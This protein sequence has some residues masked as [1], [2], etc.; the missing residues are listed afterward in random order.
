MTGLGPARSDIL[1]PL[2]R[3]NIMPK[4][5]QASKGGKCL[6]TSEN[7][8][9]HYARYGAE[10]GLSV[11]GNKFANSKEHRGCG[12][13]A[14]YNRRKQIEVAAIEN[15]KRNFHPALGELPYTDK[16][17][18]MLSDARRLERK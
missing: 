18:R 3:I 15:G 14:R 1:T 2:E 16:T 8:K 7:R 4:Q 5:S 10:H 11:K 12:P 9:Q 13:L 17:Y 6:T